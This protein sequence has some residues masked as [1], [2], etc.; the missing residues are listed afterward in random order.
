[1]NKL[2]ITDNFLTQLTYFYIG[3][4][5]L[6]FLF[7]WLVW[8]IAWPAAILF[9]Y[10]I[11]LSSKGYI[12]DNKVINDI[13]I[14]KKT[15]IYI[16]FFILIFIFFS[17]IGGYSFQNEDHRYRNAVFQDLIEKSWPVLY[18]IKGFPAENL[19]EGKATF[20]AY[21]TGY[22]LPAALFGKLFGATAASFIL[23]LWTVLGLGL[24]IY[25]LCQYFN[26]F[27]LKI[28]WLFVAWGSLYFIGSFYAFPIKEVLKGNAYLW[29]GNLLYA[30]GNTG[31]IY[32]TFNQTIVPWLVILFI[33]KQLNSKNILFLSSFIFFYG[34]FAFI[35]FVPFLIYFLYQ[36]TFKNFV[37]SEDFQKKFLEYFSF[38][39]IAGS[40][41]ILGISYFYFASNSS[42][43]V[44]NFIVP[45][46]DTYLIFLFLSAGIIILLIAD[47]NIGNGLFYIAVG[48]LLVL[49]FLQLGFGLDFTARAS[50]PSMFILMLLVGNYWLESPNTWQRKGVLIYL[51][52]AGF[53]HNMQVVR[54]IYFTG[55]E[56]ISQTDLG[57]LLARNDNAIIKNMGDRMLLNKGKNISI[58]NDLDS[59]N[60]PNNVLVRNFMGLRDQSFFYKYLAK[61]GGK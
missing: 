25:N 9:C 14:K 8:Y 42:G 38:Q 34:P 5:F 47:R 11:F 49:P 27:S 56:A 44:F 51:I 52:I 48:L 43:N 12:S 24:V 32:W 54:S 31:L 29:S 2:K 55:L 60:N 17:G 39:N 59:L 26:K 21:Y 6:I 36:N 50:I 53:G 45:E 40:L 57:K 15:L 22:W 58:K 61:K 4:P 16:G 35:G 30:D 28:F 18:Q 37:D 41:I 13:L 3:F 19:L 33:M 23:Y 20:L 46:W 10:S 7:G 1:M